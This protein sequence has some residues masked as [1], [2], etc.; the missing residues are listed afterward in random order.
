MEE[1]EEFFRAAGQYYVAGRYA[2]FA[3][4]IPVT[5]NLL[6]HAVEM[7]LKGGL[8]K[9]DVSLD[10]LKKLGHNLPNIW[11]TFKAT[12]NDPAL[13][14]F[15][16]TISSLQRFEDIRYPDL[17]VQRGMK[18]NITKQSPLKPSG[19][20]FPSMPEPAYELCV[21]DVDELVGQVFTA[22]SV[23]PPTFL[24]RLFHKEEARKYLQEQNPVSSLTSPGSAGVAL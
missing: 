9:K 17:I 5:G 18:V 22:T 23:G 21:N 11:K 12:F 2:A 1:W 24:T 10:D 16:D 3:G 15:D 20:V 6:H 14:K 13:S 4:F 8:S 19:P 7:Y